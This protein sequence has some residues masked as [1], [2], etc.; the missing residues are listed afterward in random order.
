MNGNLA[1]LRNCANADTSMSS[2]HNLIGREPTS[3]ITLIFPLLMYRLM[4]A[5][6]GASK[7]A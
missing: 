6:N 5:L 2:V 1:M 3:C 4:F 7:Q